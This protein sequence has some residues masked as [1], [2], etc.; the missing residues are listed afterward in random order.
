MRPKVIG[1]GV[2]TGP[3]HV[4]IAFRGR[5]LGGNQ[6]KIRWG[7][8]R[9]ILT[10]FL[11]AK[12]SLKFYETQDQLP[13]KIETILAPLGHFTVDDRVSLFYK[14]FRVHGFLL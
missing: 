13:D 4:F 10:A 14:Q 8:G 2:A 9:I 1:A 11:S 7:A 5:Y 6:Q 3:D 12:N